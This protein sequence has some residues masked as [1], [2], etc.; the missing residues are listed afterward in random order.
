MHGCYVWVVLVGAGTYMR[1]YVL[2]PI[3]GGAPVYMRRYVPYTRR[4]LPIHPYIRGGLSLI[5]GEKALNQQE[6]YC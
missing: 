2:A 4:Y 5:R 3:C 1:D 6:K